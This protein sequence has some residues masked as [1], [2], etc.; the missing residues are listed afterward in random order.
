MIPVLAIA[1]LAPRIGGASAGVLRRRVCCGPTQQVMPA[2][3]LINYA[4]CAWVRVAHGRRKCRNKPIAS[5]QAQR[6]RQNTCPAGKA[7][8]RRIQRCAPL[9]MLVGAPAPSGRS[10][11]Q[12]LYI[13]KQQPRLLLA[14]PEQTRGLHRRAC[15]CVRPCI[16]ACACKAGSQR[17]RLPRTN[18]SASEKGAP[19]RCGLPV[20]PTAMRRTHAWPQSP[21]QQ[22]RSDPKHLQRPGAALGRVCSPRARLLAIR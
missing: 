19:A 21:K 6:V 17:L 1:F 10:F 5:W 18:P 11:I 2:Q 3:A 4:R 13:C 12:P 14:R 15:A 16:P 7:Q 20:S 22:R 8:R 9:F